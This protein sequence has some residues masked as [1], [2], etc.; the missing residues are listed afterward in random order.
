VFVITTNKSS[1]TDICFEEFLGTLKTKIAKHQAKR[2]LE[3][4]INFKGE[5][6]DVKGLIHHLLRQ[7]GHHLFIKKEKGKEVYYIGTMRVNLFDLNKTTAKFAKFLIDKGYCSKNSEIIN[8]NVK[9]TETRVT[10]ERSWITHVE[11]LNLSDILLS[12]SNF[13]NYHELLIYIEGIKINPKNYI[14]IYSAYDKKQKMVDIYEKPDYDRFNEQD[15][16]KLV[17]VTNLLLALFSK[18][19]TTTLSRD[20]VLER[21]DTEFLFRVNKLIG[22]I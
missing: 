3:R 9:V 18:V 13:G 12:D 11:S 22:E 15:Y 20:K 19:D 8:F 6:L 16:V 21:I 17:S 7:K 1:D 10:S 14:E 2:S 5:G 4:T